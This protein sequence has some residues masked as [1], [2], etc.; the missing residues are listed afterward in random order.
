[1]VYHIRNTGKFRLSWSDAEKGCCTLAAKVSSGSRISAVSA[2]CI[3]VPLDSPT[4]FATR[5]VTDRHYALVT[6]VDEDGLEGVGFCY[7]G[8]SGGE[9][10]TTAVEQLIAPVLVGQDP[11]RIEGL[12]QEMYQEALLHGRVGSAM[13]AISALDIALWDHNARSVGLPL[14][15]YLGG[16]HSETV[17][18]YASGGYYLEGKSAGHLGEEMA[19]YVAMGFRAVKMKVG[20]LDPPEEEKR[21]AVAREAVGPDIL[22]MLDAN[23]AWAD[24]PTAMRTIERFEDY[25]PYWIE[26]PFSPDDIENH[27]RLADRTNIPVATGEIEAGRW[28]HKELLDKEAAAIL[29]TDA[30]VCGGITEFRRIAATAASFGV[31]VSP[32]WFHDLHIH[33]VGSTPNCGFVEFFPD[34]KVLNFR[35]L[36][37]R[38]LEIRS[39]ELVLPK[40]PGLGFG[41]DMEAVE[42]HTLA[43]TR[44]T[45]RA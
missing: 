17:P 27:V 39:G 35:Q 4:S 40:G 18:A 12:W 5:R 41:F 13:R 37:D 34:N 26:E 1:M 24:L 20:R 25:N 45:V 9:V 28:R 15:R 11:Y 32:H 31:T 44:T 29:Q 22:L 7:A 42:K 16:Y 36:L 21:V 33:L 6:V 2:Q 10:V 38:Q 23:N 8:S 3:K 30:A 43:D 14:H 19:G